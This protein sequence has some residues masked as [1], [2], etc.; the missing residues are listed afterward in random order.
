MVQSL[1]DTYSPYGIK[2]CD[3]ILVASVAEDGDWKRLRISA[4]WKVVTWGKSGPA[5]AGVEY[6]LMPLACWLIMQAYRLLPCACRLPMELRKLRNQMKQFVNPGS[7]LASLPSLNLSHWALHVESFWLTF[8][9]LNFF[10]CN[11]VCIFNKI[12]Y[13]VLERSPY[14]VLQEPS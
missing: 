7:I 3:G 9:T 2:I 6:W 1:S 14:T 4:I 8:W 13:L 5:L 10:F 11:P 12:H